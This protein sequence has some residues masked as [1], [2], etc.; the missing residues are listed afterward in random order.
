[1]VLRG[2]FFV[3]AHK[4]WLVGRRIDSKK[5]IPSSCIESC[6]LGTSC[7][8]D[9]TTVLSLLALKFVPPKVII[10]KTRG[11]FQWGTYMCRYATIPRS[12]MN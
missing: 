3:C 7:I 9:E 8:A 5:R 10:G 1:M 2:L 12:R 11:F 6:I 4:E